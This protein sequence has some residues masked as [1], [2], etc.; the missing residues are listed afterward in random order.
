MHSR[1]RYRRVHFQ[2]LQ[3]CNL[4]ADERAS[5]GRGDRAR[6][7]GR[8][9]DPF[10]SVLKDKED[11]PVVAS[12]SWNLPGITGARH[13]VSQGAGQDAYCAW[14]PHAVQ[15]DVPGAFHIDVGGCRK[16]L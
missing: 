15:E 10:L 12:A 6:F 3:G 16:L 11:S 9:E 14:I 4:A 1:D 8:P 7:L 13:A 2:Q 5:E